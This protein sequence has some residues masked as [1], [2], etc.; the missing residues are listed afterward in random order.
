MC[1]QTTCADTCSAISSPASEA[2]R[3]RSR[4]QDGLLTGQCGQEAALASRLVMRE[5]SSATQIL[6]TYGP[7]SCASSN[8]GDLQQCLESRLKARLEDRGSALYA[9]TWKRH[10]MD[11]GPPICALRGSAHRTSDRGFF[12]PPYP[13]PR[14]IDGRKKGNGPRRDT[15]MGF[16]N[17]DKDRR[18]IGDLNHRLSGWLM[19]FPDSWSNCAPTEM[20]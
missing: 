7:I 16:V 19:G 18:R 6:G 9:L 4:S 14:A 5:S 11:S 20:P 10:A 3:S 1:S 2:G 8:P 13:T 15:L 17:Y 12:S